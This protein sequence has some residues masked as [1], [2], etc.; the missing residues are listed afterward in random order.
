[1]SKSHDVIYQ[2]FHT[3]TDYVLVRT[4]DGHIR[5]YLVHGVTYYHGGWHALLSGT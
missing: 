2:T 1:M 5:R 4:G 3:W